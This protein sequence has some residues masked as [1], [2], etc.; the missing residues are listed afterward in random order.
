MDQDGVI[1]A[2][3]LETTSGGKRMAMAFT[4]SSLEPVA[5]R[6]AQRLLDQGEVRAKTTVVWDITATRARR[7]SNPPRRRAT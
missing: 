5:L 6:A 2:Y 1:S 3:R 4:P 7:E